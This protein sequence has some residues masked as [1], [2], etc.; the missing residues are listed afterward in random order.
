MA[1]QAAT[2][3]RMAALFSS[4]FDEI[5]RLVLQSRAEVRSS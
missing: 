3:E 2:A 5:K 4:K 1:M